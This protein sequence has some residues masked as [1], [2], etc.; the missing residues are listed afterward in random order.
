MKFTHLE[1]I[2]RECNY[3]S[4]EHLNVNMPFTFNNFK[5]PSQSCVFFAFTVILTHLW[6]NLIM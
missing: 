1:D 4:H 3:E 5:N 6:I 2:F